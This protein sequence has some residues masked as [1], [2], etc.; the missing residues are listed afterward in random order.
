MHGTYTKRAKTRLVKGMISTN[1]GITKSKPCSGFGNIAQ[2]GTNIII[3]AV[4]VNMIIP[5][6]IKNSLVDSLLSI[7]PH[8]I[9]GI[10]IR[11]TGNKI[12]M[13]GNIWTMYK[14]SSI[15]IDIRYNMLQNLQSQFIHWIEYGKTSDKIT[16]ITMFIASFKSNFRILIF[17]TLNYFI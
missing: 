17:I 3:I 5:I 6:E 11:K 7:N 13:S 10:R 16:F 12:S 1:S 15:F 9:Q 2:M 4:N 14:S 8:K